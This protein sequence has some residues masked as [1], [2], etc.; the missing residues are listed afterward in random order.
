MLHSAQHDV[1]IEKW[2]TAKDFDPWKLRAKTLSCGEERVMTSN[3]KEPV[4]VV[5]QMSGAYDALNTIIPYADPLY[6]DYRPVL[7]VDPER[8][9]TIDDKV[10]FNPA[11]APLKELYDQGKVAVIQGI[12]Y[13]NPI[14][15]HFRSMDI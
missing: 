14:R 3:K 8:V 6:M 5:L 10:G 1:S 13:P 15:S 9:L 12:G 2:Q 7:K 11:L 4:L